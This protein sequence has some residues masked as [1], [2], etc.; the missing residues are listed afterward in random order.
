MVHDNVLQVVRD[1]DL[2]P[3]PT[4][5]GPTL[6]RESSPF[7]A[8]G[9]HRVSRALPPNERLDRGS[10]ARIDDRYKNRT[11]RSN[12][13][14]DSLLALAIAGAYA[15]SKA[16]GQ[17]SLMSQP[18]DSSSLTW[19]QAPMRHLLALSW[20][21]CLSTISYAIYT[22]VDTWFVSHLGNEALASASLGGVLCFSV[23]WFSRGILAS[24]KLKISQE[25]GADSDSNPD[26]WLVCG[27]R[28]S[29]ILALASAACLI[30]LAFLSLHL[31]ETIAA[32]EGARDYILLRGSG[33]FFA[34]FAACFREALFGQSESR[35]ALWGTM[36]G[37]AANILLD[38]L[39]IL[40]FSWGVQGAA[41]ATALAY[42]VDLAVLILLDQLRRKESKRPRLD[43]KGILR[44]LPGAKS[45][46]ELW[47]LG[48]PIGT[49]NFLEVG[50]FAVLTGIVARVGNRDLAAHQIVLQVLH[51]AFLP[52][53]A[54]G[55][56]CS[57]MV[58]E[59]HGAHEPQWMMRMALRS[60]LLVG[61]FGLLVMLGIWLF[62]PSVARS[63]S[64]DDQLVALMIQLFHIA[65]LFQISDGLNIVGRCALR[66]IQDLRFVS[67]VTI[68]LTWGLTCPLAY[69]LVLEL[70]Y[71][72]S[73]VW[74]AILTEVSLV[75]AILWTRMVL[76]ARRF[77]QA[78]T[79]EVSTRL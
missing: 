28:L 21:I 10:P 38:A 3:H 63:F 55:E 26:P 18:P 64:Q 65:A 24:V 6:L 31:T 7:T 78:S 40:Y 70:G 35:V 43:W 39:F 58:S 79:L 14:E 57:I 66:G 29:L 23:I 4:T 59:A 49:A 1:N 72:A 53:L 42:S 54:L 75:A 37:T 33:I 46:R 60:L 44:H 20:P 77:A 52:I 15:E 71:G 56:G 17:A 34:L 8:S 2:G 32:G 36:A 25:R 74:W 61:T 27:L 45:M 73:G 47:T 68:A 76:K 22:I 5:A 69:L 16:T 67:G 13:R 19:V 50:A 30:P 51:F 41:L 12:A 62:A 48:W 11:P 9:R